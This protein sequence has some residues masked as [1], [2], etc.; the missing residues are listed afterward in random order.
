MICKLTFTLSQISVKETS[1]LTDA[2]KNQILESIIWIY[3]STIEMDPSGFEPETSCLQGR[4]ST[5]ELRA[6]DL[7]YFYDWQLFIKVS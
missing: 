3:R 4:R 1:Y 7:I 6:Q 2:A 5:P